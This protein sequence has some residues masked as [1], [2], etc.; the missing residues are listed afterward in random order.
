TETQFQDNFVIG[1]KVKC[2]GIVTDFQGNTQIVLLPIASEVTQLGASIPPPVMLDIDTFHQFDG[3]TQVEQELSGEKYENVYVELTNVS[4]VNVLPQSNG[5]IFWT[6]QDADGD[7]MGT[8]D[9]SGHIR[10]DVID[11]F[12]TASGISFTPAAFD[13]PQV[14]SLLSFIRGIVVQK[15]VSGVSQ[16]TIAPITLGDIGPATAAAPVVSNVV[17]MIVVPTTSQDQTITAS[18]VDPDG[19]VGSATLHYAVGLGSTTFMTAPMTNTSGNT[20]SGTIPAVSTD[21]TYVI[22]F[23]SATDND[24]NTTN[25][26]NTS[27][28]NSYYLVLSTGINSISDIQ[29]NPLSINDSPYRNTKLNGVSVQGTVTATTALNDLGFV[30]IQDG[31][32][33]WSGISFANNVNVQS[34]P[35]A[36]TLQRGDRLLVT[37][38]RVF[39]NFGFTRLDTVAYTVISSGNPLPS[40]I[41]NVNIDSVSLGK[42]NY[43]EV[44]ESMLLE[45]TDVY[46]T[47]LNPDAAT[48]GDFGE[49]AIY[50]STTPGNQLRVDDY[51]NDIFDTFHTDSLTL[52]QPLDFIR[53]ILAFANGNW[54]LLPRNKD[55]IAGFFTVSSVRGVD[56]Y[57]AIDVFPNPASSELNV[58]FANVNGDVNWTMTDATGRV[59]NASSFRVNGGDAYTVPMEKFAAGV[60]FIRV[61][62]HQG[63]QTVQVVKH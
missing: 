2:T 28:T 55:D 52:N 5:R 46:V 13:T 54:K 62:T 26:P 23:I 1:N 9:A 60:Y 33:P 48:G 47:S 17:E 37:S 6:V 38:A 8:H 14:N 50:E 30:V 32:A 31:V 41:M 49:W 51:S 42:Y 35:A 44:Y 57:H 61:Q 43:T 21:S 3:S 59:M 4:V 7:A 24:G 53:G 63:V 34:G 40:P 58:R 10:N 27:A 36:S 16:Y 11:T 45:Y 20:W 29:F 15:T 39:E 18:I 12:C 25:F 19:S 22:Y 56:A